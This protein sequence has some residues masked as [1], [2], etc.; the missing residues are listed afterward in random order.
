[1]T[2]RAFQD[3]IAATAR[4]LSWRVFHI[5]AARTANGWRTPVAF[6]GQGFPDLVLVRERIIYA[7]IKLERGRLSPEQVAWLEDLRAAGQ[8]V[9]VWR[10]SDWAS[11]AIEDVLRNRTPAHGLAA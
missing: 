5:R 1:M 7:E 11:G 8:E 2:E 10:P 3:S 6:D 9:Y 4:L